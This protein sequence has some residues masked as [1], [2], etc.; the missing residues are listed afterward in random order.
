MTPPMVR[1]MAND[2]A[3]DGGRWRTMGHVCR[4]SAATDSPRTTLGRFVAHQRAVG[5]RCRP[6]AHIAAYLVLLRRKRRNTWARRP[7]SL[8]MRD[9]RQ[10]NVCTDRLALRSDKASLFTS[11]SVSL[12]YGFLA[13]YPASSSRLKATLW[14]NAR[15]CKICKYI[16]KTCGYIRQLKF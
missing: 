14:V 6:S 2:V 9:E 7:R 13:A 15:V 8:A 4:S 16:S 1:P 5:Q 10:K 12:S 3:T 11:L